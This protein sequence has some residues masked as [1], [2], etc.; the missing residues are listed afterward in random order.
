MSCV[1]SDDKGVCVCVCVFVC[2][3]VFYVQTARAEALAREA[4]EAELRGALIEYNLTAV[5]AVITALNQQLATGACMCG[6][7]E[8]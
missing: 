7:E 6:V 2:A 1:R 8:L 3:C 4:D 5:D